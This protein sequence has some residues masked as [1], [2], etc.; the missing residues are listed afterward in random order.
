MGYQ[1]GY[2]LNIQ[3]IGNLYFFFG[4]LG[5]SGKAVAER[6]QKKGNQTHKKG[7]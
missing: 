2:L 7:I 1:L 6:K 5:Y 3:H 4:R